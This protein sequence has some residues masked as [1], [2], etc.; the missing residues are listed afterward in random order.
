[1]KAN[2]DYATALCNQY[3]ALAVLLNNSKFRGMQMMEVLGIDK[4]AVSK[5]LSQ[6]LLKGLIKMTTGG[7]YSPSVSLINIIR[8]IN[9]PQGG[10]YE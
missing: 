6:M 4:D 7:L 2:T 9:K 5:L 10:L 3:P 1:M 8:S